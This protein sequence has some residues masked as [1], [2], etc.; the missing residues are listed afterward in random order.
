MRPAGDAAPT[1]TVETFGI[2]V[3]ELL[4]LARRFVTVVETFR[5]IATRVALRYAVAAAEGD[6]L[7][8]EP[9][10][11]GLTTP[12]PPMAPDRPSTDRPRTAPR[13][14]R[15]RTV[16]DSGR[17]PRGAAPSGFCHRIPIT[18]GQVQ[19]DSYR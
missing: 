14:R 7:A 4:V 10:T 2:V 19:D 8:D 17:R 12:T 18:L 1:A 13:P 11:D 3:D 9:L 5:G 6:L 16:G 15:L